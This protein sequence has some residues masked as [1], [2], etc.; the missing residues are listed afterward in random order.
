MRILIADDHGM[1]REAIR[2]LIEQESAMQV[3]A[4]AEDGETAVRLADQ[5]HPDAILMDIALPKLDG[6]EAT[7]RIL[8]TLPTTKVIALSMHAEEKVIREVLEAGASG[9]IV[10]G[11]IWTSLLKALQAAAA[12]KCYLS[13]CIPDHIAHDRRGSGDADTHGTNPDLTTHK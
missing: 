13:P 12:G 3:V 2:S 9:Y 5:L 7:R 8:R 10:K 6:I 1:F 11:D 4:E